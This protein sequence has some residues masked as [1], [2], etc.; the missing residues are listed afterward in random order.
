MKLSHTKLNIILTCPMTYFLQ[1]KEGISLKRKKSALEI[2]SAVHWGI[3]HDTEDLT[4]YVKERN[5]GELIDYASNKDWIL[6]EGMIH[7]YLQ[8]K[9]QIFDELL[10]DPDDENKRLEVLYEAH[11]LELNAHMKSKVYKE[12][13][14]F[15]GIIDLLL[16][17]EKGWIV[18]DY[19]TSSQK[20][21]WDK[22]LDQLYR[23]IYLIKNSEE[24]KDYK[25]LDLP[26]IKIAIINIRKAS[27]RQKAKENEQQFLARLK[28]E[29]E[30]NED[31]NYLETHIFEKEDLDENLIN[32]YIQNLQTMC[33][34]AAEID[35]EGD[36][37]GNYFINFNNAFSVY[38]KGDYWDIFFGTKDNYLLYKIKDVYFDEDTEEIETERDCVP[39]DMEVINKEKRKKIINKYS[40]FKNEY[41]R[42]MSSNI[43]LTEDD[44]LTYF[45]ENFIVDEGLLKNY[46][47]VYINNLYTE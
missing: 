4:E 23:Y 42:I 3:E 25:E 11:E 15:M 24:L 10:K 28:F 6:A 27:I 45:E 26:V 8:N 46:Y 21:D 5:D 35:K 22:Y 12:G 16:L 9:D 37:L 13:N 44:I 20:P 34:Y 33:E 38:G 47:T 40:L 39:I 7:G 1:Y 41:E 43:P 18:V 32:L 31:N 2:G 29:Y 30:L 14:D 19:K 36:K 17:T